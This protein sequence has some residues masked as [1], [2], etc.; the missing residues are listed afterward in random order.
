VNCIHP[1]V[2]RSE[3]AVAAGLDAPPDPVAFQKFLDGLHELGFAGEPADIA[4]AAIFLTSPLARWITGAELD[5]DGGFGL[6][7]VSLG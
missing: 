6:G 2:V 4:A 3:I 7:S 1:G 5:V